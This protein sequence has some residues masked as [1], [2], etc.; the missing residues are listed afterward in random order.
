M[1]NE[2]KIW[3]SSDGEFLRFLQ[4]ER[5]RESAI[6]SAWGINYWIVGAAIIGLLGYAFHQISNE[7]DSFNWLL[8][9]YYSVVLGALLISVATILSPVLHNRRWKNETRVTTL[10]ENFPRDENFGK[11]FIAYASSAVLSTCHK[12]YGVITWLFIILCTIEIG[13]CLAMIF[14]G[15]KLILVEPW[16]HVFSKN[17]WEICYRV[18]EVLICWSIIIIALYTWGVQYCMAVKEFEMSWVLAIIV[19]VIW[20]THNRIRERNCNEID[21][22]IDQ[23]V[24][25]SL[26]KEDAYFY[27]LSNSQGY[28]ITDILQ[29]EYDRVKPFREQMKEGRK[30]HEK[31]LRMIKEKRLKYDDSLVYYEDLKQEMKL[32]DEVQ[33][34]TK[35]VYDKMKEILRLE[36]RSKSIELFKKRIND[37]NTFWEESNQFIEESNHITHE[38]YV[39]IHSFVCIKYGGL[40]GVV[41]CPHRNEKFSLWYMIKH[42]FY[43]FRK[44]INLHV[45]RN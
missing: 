2:R 14:K 34:A 35:H 31:Y 9:T 32:V 29:F 1:E 42:K 21:D 41:D 6:S 23:F 10:S 45:E 18:A 36:T 17:K 40:C 11:G 43:F 37:F 26:S 30:N 38:I 4:A 19:S 3:E 13:I 7:Y 16:G 5:N 39:F 15:R 44:I 24:Y 8:M 22:I 25:G 27:L 28:D 12:E 33:D 20:I